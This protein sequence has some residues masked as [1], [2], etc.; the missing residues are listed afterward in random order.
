MSRVREIDEAASQR[1]AAPRTVAELAA[2]QKA[3]RARKRAER[4][5]QARRRP[6]QAPPAEPTTDRRLGR[7]RGYASTAGQSAEGGR[8][9]ARYEAR[10]TLWEVSTRKGVR[11]CGKT[12]VSGG[13]TT[14][15]DMR[16]KGSH[17]GLMHCGLIWVCPVCS[18]KIRAVRADTLAEGSAA[19]CEAGHAVALV[20]LTIRHYARERLR[21]LVKKVAAAWRRAF[22]GRPWKTMQDRYGITG[23]ARAMEVTHGEAN[24]WHVHFH[25]LM[26]TERR[27]SQDRADAFRGEAAARW[28]DAC[29]AVGAYRPSDER[30]VR[31][32]VLGKGADP[33][34]MARY[35]MKGQDGKRAAFELADPDTKRGKHGH[36][37]P[38]EILAAFVA[39]ADA[40]DLDLWH[41]YEEA[42][43]GQRALVWSRGM[44]DR[45]AELVELDDRT[46]AEIVEE[47][48]EGM[49]PVALIPAETWKG[50]VVRH[51]GRALA[52]LHAAEDGGQPA[53]RALVA[54][55]G[56]QW[57][58]DVLD[59]PEP[60]TG[61][62]TAA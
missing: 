33:S 14:A 26:F 48:A 58:R 44:R 34:D 59:P 7:D 17:L 57:G 50:H 47:E 36:R 53:L 40:D 28:A 41:A 27:W 19:W 32:D 23:Y 15:L 22:T 51:R 38:F 42:M 39:T 30:G 10:E 24:G 6:Q 16:G 56:L 21:D 54:S 45:L 3:L 35:V 29:Q 46:D 11:H 5:A 25:V 55:W 8:R 2:Q 49:L 37:T 43:T 20:T 1:P 62:Q 31:V 52:L 9:G 12:P 13:V 18:A 61:R 4:A 60:P